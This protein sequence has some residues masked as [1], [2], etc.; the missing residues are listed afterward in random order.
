MSLKGMKVKLRLRQAV[1]WG[2]TVGEHCRQVSCLGEAGFTFH[3]A[4]DDLDGSF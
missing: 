4:A 3:N 2:S 1:L